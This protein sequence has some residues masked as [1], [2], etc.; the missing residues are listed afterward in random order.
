MKRNL[1][2]IYL[3]GYVMKPCN[4]ILLGILCKNSLANDKLIDNIEE[5]CNSVELYIKT[6]NELYR[7]KMNIFKK[8]IA[9]EGILT[10]EDL[11]Q[12]ANEC[13]RIRKDAAS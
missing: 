6:D 3:K 5:Y 1:Q 13:I 12:I 8:L 10:E 2:K 11:D 4:E 7:E 9:T